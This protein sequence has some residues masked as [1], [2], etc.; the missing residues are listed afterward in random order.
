MVPSRQ[1]ATKLRYMGADSRVE[2]AA[3]RGAAAAGSGAAG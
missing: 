1:S 3:A 2:T